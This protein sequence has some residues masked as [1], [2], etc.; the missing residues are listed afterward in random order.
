MII[1]LSELKVLLRLLNYCGRFLPN[2][3]TTIHPLNQLQSKGQKWVWL[4]VCN[5]AFMIPVN[6]YS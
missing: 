5:K 4:A 1:H 3:S 6:H 2:L